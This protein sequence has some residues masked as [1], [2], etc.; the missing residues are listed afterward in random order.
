MLYKQLGG[1]DSLSRKYYTSDYVVWYERLLPIYF[2]DTHVYF[3]K[4]YD[5]FKN[6]CMNMIICI[7]C[8]QHLLMKVEKMLLSSTRPLFFF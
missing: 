4:T 2:V 6:A 3:V 5:I 7:E 1:G 8:A